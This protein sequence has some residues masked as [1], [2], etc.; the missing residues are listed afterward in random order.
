MS[1]LDKGSSYCIP[2]SAVLNCTQYMPLLV[3]PRE[4]GKVRVGFIHS[5]T[6]LFMLLFERTKDKRKETNTKVQV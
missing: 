4:I 1:L 3:Q 2:Y 5:V 6:L